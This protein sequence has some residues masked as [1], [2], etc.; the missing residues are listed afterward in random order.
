MP[1]ALP[2][3]VWAFPSPRDADPDG[4]VAVGGDL[5]PATLVAAYARGLFPMPLRPGTLGWFSPDPRAVLEPERMH[6]SRTLSRSYA[7]MEVTVDACF[8]EVVLGCAHP[9]RPHGWIDDDFVEAYSELHR[10]GWAHSIEAWSDDRLAGGL[11]GVAIGA[12]F[13]GESMFHNET[14]GSK[15]ALRGLCELLGGVANVLFDVQ[16]ATPHLESL[17]VEEIPRDEYLDR[18]ALAV[19]SPGPDWRR[20]EIA[21]P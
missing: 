10:L 13:A 19:G 1:E 3:S 20:N 15:V 18:L 6:V 11:Y 7:R 12:F 4:P 5:E 17:G 9:S 2:P 21:F 14:D 8:T 16:W